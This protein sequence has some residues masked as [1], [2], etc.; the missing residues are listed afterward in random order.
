MRADQPLFEDSRRV[1]SHDEVLLREKIP[2]SR[3]SNPSTL[4]QARMKR[5]NL[6]FEKFWFSY[7]ISNYSVGTHPTLRSGHALTIF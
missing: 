7:S 1:L 5:L 4:H 6:F 2:N 3:R